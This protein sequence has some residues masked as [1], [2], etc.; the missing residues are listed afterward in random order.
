MQ[1]R[2]RTWAR[3]GQA[4]LVL[5]KVQRVRARRKR[6]MTAS[7]RT[8]GPAFAVLLDESEDA[9]TLEVGT[10]DRHSRDVRHDDRTDAWRKLS[11]D[12]QAESSRPTSCRRHREGD[13]RYGTD[14]EAS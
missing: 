12:A 14:Q 7:V 2:G 9:S 3:I 5:P 11:T 8:I 6:Q 1:R 13:H 4:D 10:T